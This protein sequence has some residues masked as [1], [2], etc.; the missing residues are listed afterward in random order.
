MHS[1][2]VPPATQPDNTKVNKSDRDAS[3]PTADQAKNNKNDRETMAKIRRSITRD[4]MVVVPDAHNVKVIAQNGTVTLSG[5]VRS[6]E[7]K[8]AMRRRRPPLPAGT[9]SPARLP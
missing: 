6:D 2:P 7:E 3:A 1:S 5:P 4:K 8:R 9:M